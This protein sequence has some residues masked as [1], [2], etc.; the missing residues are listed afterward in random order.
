[1]LTIMGLYWLSHQPSFYRQTA[2][3]LK[4]FTLFFFFAG[5]WAILA[6]RTHYTIDILVAIYTGAG[7]WWSFA[8]FWQ[9]YL[10]RRLVDV[11]RFYNKA[12]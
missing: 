12:F 5:I 4:K 11:D 2:A 7:I 9:N 3:I 1:M 6:N 8:Y 10:A